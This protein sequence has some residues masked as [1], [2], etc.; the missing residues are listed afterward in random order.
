MLALPFSN[1]MAAAEEIQVY[2]DEMNNPGEFG[3]EIHNNYVFS[4][5]SVPDY[6]GA[7]TPTHVFRLTPEFSYGLTDS[8]ELGA[9][10]LSSRDALNNLNVD[11][12]KLRLKYIAPKEQ[13]QSWFLGSNLEIGYVSRRMDQNPWA[14]QLKG[15]YGNRAG[16][17]LFAVNPNV[18]WVVSGPV[19]APATL[20]LDSKVAYE[21][22]HDYAVGF[23]SY[24][25]MGSVNGLIRPA[26]QGQNLY[27]VLDTA[28][29]GLDL[30][31]GVGRGFSAVSD[32]WLAKAIVSVPFG[33]G[34]M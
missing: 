2:M 23:E 14:A 5:N 17:W 31:F 12:E 7:Q 30:N 15:I 29:D 20:E 24:N 28:V 1:A 25:G 34:S 16:R 18:T 22:R 21:I 4:G 10:L 3:L 13:G 26:Q 27:V 6:P 8:F 11:G 33:K 19:S 9:Y 32:K